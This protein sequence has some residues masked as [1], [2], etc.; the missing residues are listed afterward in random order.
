MLCSALGHLFFKTSCSLIG[1]G[2]ISQSSAPG[3]RMV[4]AVL[5]G[6][7]RQKRDQSE[8]SIR[9]ALCYGDQLFVFLFLAEVCKERAQYE[10]A[11]LVEHAAVTMSRETVTDFYGAQQLLQNYCYCTTFC[12][13]T[14]AAVR[15][16]LGTCCCRGPRWCGTCPGDYVGTQRRSGL[17]DS[18]T[19]WPAAPH[20]ATTA[21][22]R[23]KMTIDTTSRIVFRVLS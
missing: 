3:L 14:G 19:A 7:Q 21:A 1:G 16:Q 23:H 9:P 22:L 2:K 12:F 11:G 8:F 4:C 15:T 10:T 17:K 18:V 5:H 6:R 20:P 13:V